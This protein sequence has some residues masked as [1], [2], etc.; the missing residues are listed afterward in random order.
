MAK[1]KKEK[2]PGLFAQF[3]EGV[4]FLRAENP[5]AVPVSISLGIAIFFALSLIGFIMSGGFIIGI[6]LWI[7]LAV[8]TA[9]L[10]TLL[11]ITRAT[12]RAVFK[13]YSSEP[14]RLSLVVGSLT[15]RTF[16]GSNQPVAINPR[17]KDMI[18]RVVGPAGVILMGEGAPTSTKAMLED[19]RR[20]VQRMATGV[21][22]TTFY[23]SETDGGVPLL[24]MDKKV[25]ALKRTMNKQEI[26]AVQNR[27]A[28]MD[29]RSGLP[30]PKGM[31]PM[32][33]RPSKKM[34]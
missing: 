5:K 22:V 30:I 8:A 28:A 10:S 3:R 7:V 14:G 31:D 15:R 29:V 34:R 33:M 1:D 25:R 16:K 2:A 6:A 4:T 18:F 21:T 24:Q 12:N 19:E 20:K 32:K 13:K 9:Y 26:F 17:T 11:L 23:C 27:L